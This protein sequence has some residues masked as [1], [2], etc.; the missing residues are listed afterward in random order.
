MKCEVKGCKQKILSIG[1]QCNHCNRKFCG[2]HRIPEDHLCPG[3]EE[4]K[5]SEILRNETSLMDNKA[6]AE[7]VV[8]F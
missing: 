7:K 1:I 5:K 6:V 3:L 2:L 8:S 4:L